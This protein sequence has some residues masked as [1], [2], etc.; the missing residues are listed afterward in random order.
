MTDDTL[1][2]LAALA[3]LE[4]LDGD[5]AESFALLA[6]QS[7]DCQRELLAFR[8]VAELMPLGL[9]PVAPAPGLRQRVL[10]A[11]LSPSRAPRASVRPAPRLWLGLAAAVVLACGLGFWRARA[12][13][14]QALAE[15]QAAE[16]SAARA[17]E[18]L[19]A[20]ELRLV[21]LQRS[22]E[23]QRGLQQ[24]VSYQDTRLTPLA[25]LPAAPG[26]RGRMLWSAQSR[27]AVLLAIGLPPAPQGKAYEVWVI[28]RGAPTPAGVFQVD[29]EGKAAFRLPDVAETAEAKTFAVTLEPAEGTA[30][31]TGP[32]VLAGAVIG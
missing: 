32:M 12:E 7:A 8:R 4:A 25:G 28:G 6:S 23:Q 31:P 13:R 27:E 22:Y 5:E 2:D 18:Q 21:A 30:S 3:A 14:D 24:L 11:A 15:V 9:T 26:A 17:Q 29:A 20:A 10:D 16:A 19:R 1:R